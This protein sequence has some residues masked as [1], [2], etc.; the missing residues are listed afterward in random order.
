TLEARLQAALAAQVK[1]AAA[2]SKGGAAAAVVLDPATGEILARAQWPDY[3]PA[4]KDWRK[5]RLEADPKFMGIYGGWSDK[6]GLHGVFQAGSVFKILSA[7][8]AL[9][10]GVVKPTSEESCPTTS[11]PVF[12]CDQRSEGRVSFTL[13]GWSRPIHDH[14]DG[15]GQGKLDLV[16]AITRSSN[17]YFGQLALSLGSLPYRKLREEGV[18]F[19][20]PGLLSEAEGPWT[21][22]GSAGSRRLAQTGFGQGAG[23]WSVVQAARL[24]GAVANGGVYRRCPAEML[25]GTACVA[26]PILPAGS[27]VAPILSG[28][29]GVMQSGTGARLT[30][31]KGIR[32]YGKTGTADAPGTADERPWGIK[33]GKETAPHSWFV[34]IAEPDENNA[35][36]ADAPGRYVVA[37]VVPHGGFGASAAGPLVMATLQEMQT[38]GYFPKVP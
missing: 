25:L 36:V 5:L 6:T 4:G 21:G 9:R 34:A 24:L 32:V 7:V 12:T 11:D 17:V 16:T 23:S 14:G 31:P 10:E 20:N 2:R 26:T 27:D 29:L 3:D 1:T 13:P 37:A 8:V 33:P 19:G 35:C 18:E 28:M 15:G 38:L 22:L 30:E